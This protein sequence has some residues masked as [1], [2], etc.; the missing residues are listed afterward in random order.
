MSIL[1]IGNF[2]INPRHIKLHG[3]LWFMPCKDASGHDLGTLVCNALSLPKNSAD[4][5]YCHVIHTNLHGVPMPCDTY[6][7]IMC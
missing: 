2:R 3:S 4:C 1:C 7:A 5:G 6:Y